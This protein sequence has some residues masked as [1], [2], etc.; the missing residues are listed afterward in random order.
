[1][2]FYLQ[3]AQRLADPLGYLLPLLPA[4]RFVLIGTQPADRGSHEDDPINIHSGRLHA[5]ADDV[6]TLSKLK[7]IFAPEGSRR[8]FTA[9]SSSKS[10]PPYMPQHS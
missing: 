7:A 5:N 6:M 8:T 4:S 9:A 2:V 3:E 10:S 1:M